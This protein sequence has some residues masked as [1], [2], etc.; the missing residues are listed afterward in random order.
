[1][2]PQG[3]WYWWYPNATKKFK[4]DVVLPRMI[5]IIVVKWKSKFSKI[6][7]TAARKFTKIQESRLQYLYRQGNWYEWSSITTKNMRSFLVLP[8][9][10]KYD[11]NNCS[12]ENL[13]FQTSEELLQGN[14]PKFGNL[15]FNTCIAREID[16][17]DLL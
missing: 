7:G 3:N 16:M 14:S 5:K 13:N 10:S 11:Q 8:P 2:N 15:A 17:N 9:M 6:W 1:M 4:L 12:S